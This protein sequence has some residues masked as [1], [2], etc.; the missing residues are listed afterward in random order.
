MIQ[1]CSQTVM[2]QKNNSSSSEE[3]LSSMKNSSSSS[4]EELS[5]MENS[6]SSSEEELSSMEN[7]SSSSEEELSSM[8]NSSSSSEMTRAD[9]LDLMLTSVSELASFFENQESNKQVLVKGV[10]TR[11][12]ADDIDGDAHQ[13]FI[14]RLDN[15]QT[16]LIAHNI[17]LAPRVPDIKTNQLIYVYGEYEYNDEGGVVHWT[18]KD[19]DGSHED[20][21]IFY[22]GVQYD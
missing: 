13:R 2:P 18:H 21:F 19:P 11:L 1:G 14:I 17:D 3:E 16:L 12:L 5:S 4:E 9:S 8:E 15:D 6:S 20:G 7:S 22:N 10:I